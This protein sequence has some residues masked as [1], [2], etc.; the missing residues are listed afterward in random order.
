MTPR[1]CYLTQGT[2]P[3]RTRFHSEYFP[4]RKHALMQYYDDEVM[5]NKY[6]EHFRNPIAQNEIPIDFYENKSEIFIDADL[7]GV[8]KS[9]VDLT[10]DNTG[11]LHIHAKKESVT[12]NGPLQLKEDEKVL[13]VMDRVEFEMKYYILERC[14]DNLNRKILLP[15][16]ADR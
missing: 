2:K 6:K 14:A 9:N 11:I 13:T 3:M 15:A 12:A 1:H 4:G 8:N 5:P 16:N 10:V 7:P